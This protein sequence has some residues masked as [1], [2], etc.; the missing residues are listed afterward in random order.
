MPKT[1]QCLLLCEKLSLWHPPKK[2]DAKN[3]AASTGNCSVK[4]SDTKKKEEKKPD[5]KNIAVSTVVWKT[6]KKNKKKPD[7]KNIA[8]S[9]V[10]WKTLTPRKASCQRHCSVYCSVK[11]FDTKKK[12]PDAKNIAVSTVVWK[13]LTPRKAS[14]QRHCSVFCSLNDY[15]TEKGL[16][17]KT[18]CISNAATF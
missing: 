3:I 13:T 1:L 4:D 17:P 11:D 10:A 2:P 15:D 5:T 7:V 14:C 8:V 16:M 9:T 6:D 18:K 12:K